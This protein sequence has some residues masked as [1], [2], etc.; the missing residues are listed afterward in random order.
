MSA[1][2]CLCRTIWSGEGAARFAF[3]FGRFHTKQTKS[4]KGP[5]ETKTLVV[6]SSMTTK[7]AIPTAREK[8]FGI[9]WQVFKLF[10]PVNTL[11]INIVFY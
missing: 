7:I 11:W 6:V 4:D 3:L 5:I 9:S 2:L 10:L 1:D 8:R